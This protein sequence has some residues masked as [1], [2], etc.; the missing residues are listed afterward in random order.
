MVSPD[1]MAHPGG[2]RLAIVALHRCGADATT[3]PD[4]N[5]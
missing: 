2:A 1:Q 4:P 3:A 5:R